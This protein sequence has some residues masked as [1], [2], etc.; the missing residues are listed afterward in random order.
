MSRVIVPTEV[1]ELFPDQQ[2]DQS[3]LFLK[4]KFRNESLNRVR[5]LFILDQITK[6][7]LYSLKNT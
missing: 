5:S 1:I 4:G 2:S 6:I 7:G 3:V